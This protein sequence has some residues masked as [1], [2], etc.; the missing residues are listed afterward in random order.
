M[1][2]CV[3]CGGFSGAIAAIAF[4]IRGADKPM[5]IASSGFKLVPSA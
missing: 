1:F 5:F 2:I 3:F 4:R